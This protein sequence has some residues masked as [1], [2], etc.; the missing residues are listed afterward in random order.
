MEFKFFKTLNAASIKGGYFMKK[1]SILISVMAAVLFFATLAWSAQIGAITGMTGNVDI[2]PAADT[3]ARAV[4]VG[5]TVNEGDI[6][7]TKSKSKA[8]VSFSDGNILRLAENTRLKISEYMSGKNKNVSVFNLMRGKIL[9]TVKTVG[10]VGGS[11]EV[12]TPTTVCGVRGTIFFNYHINGVSGALFQEGEG[13]GF[14]AKMPQDVRAIPAGHVMI[15]PGAD[16]P[17]HLRAFSPSELKSLHM[18]TDPSSDFFQSRQT[19]Q[20]GAP[21]LQPGED[22]GTLK[23][24]RMRTLDQYGPAS[25]Q[26]KPYIPPSIPQG[27]PH[28]TPPH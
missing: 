27:S 25:G 20:G 1:T 17:P 4:A 28:S 14:N 15:V 24:E 7:R 19:L 8:E 11:Y 12:H 10:A 23:R 16:Q 18:E 22:D 13:Y 2:T 5:D 6:L 26:T 9:N 3:K 21:D